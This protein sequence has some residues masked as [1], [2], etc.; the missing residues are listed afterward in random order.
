MLP[1][2]LNNQTEPIRQ[3]IIH[4][5]GNVVFSIREQKGSDSVVRPCDYD[6]P[7]LNTKGQLYDMSND[8]FEKMI[9]MLSILKLL[10]NL[11]CKL[12][13]IRLKVGVINYHD[14]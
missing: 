3:D 13:N 7:I 8:V 10:M 11:K 14:F 9:C 6:A 12:N 5:S 2:L 1:V 4:L